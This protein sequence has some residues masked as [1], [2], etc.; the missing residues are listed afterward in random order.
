V[1]GFHIDNDIPVGLAE[2]LRSYGHS[3]V[4]ARDLGLAA[5]EDPAHLL[6]AAQHGRILVTHN[7]NDYLLLH[8][9]WLLW[10]MPQ[11]HAG[12]LIMKQQKL[13]VPQMASAID[14]FVRHVQS[15]EN[16]VYEWT[17]SGRWLRS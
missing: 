6:T 15:L 12:I 17:V 9:A 16:Q 3:A 13:L 2:A 5:A 11:P 1:A 4:T 7:K 14:S 10:S 8:S